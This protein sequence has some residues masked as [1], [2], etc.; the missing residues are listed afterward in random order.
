MS[1]SITEKELAET[2]RNECDINRH[3][4]W[5]HAAR[6]IAEA[7]GVNLAPEKPEPGTIGITCDGLAAYVDGG[8]VWRV[9]LANGD[10]RNANDA[11]AI[12]PARVVP[13]ELGQGGERKLPSRARVEHALIDGLKGTGEDLSYKARQRATNAVMELLEASK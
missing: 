8:G 1:K 3:N 10:W 5:N 6:K 2:L 12:T 4:G 11:D 9:I 7:M 13:A